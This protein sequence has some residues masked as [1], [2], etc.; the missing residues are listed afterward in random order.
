MAGNQTF[1]REAVILNLLKCLD[2]FCSLLVDNGPKS[3]IRAF[4][5]ASSYVVHRRIVYETEQG[6]K[7]GM[8]QGLNESGFLLVRDDLGTIH[9]LYAGGVRLD[10]S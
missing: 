5:Q 2:D 6:L 10:R 9:T 3:V 7:K 4:T 1:S 8:T